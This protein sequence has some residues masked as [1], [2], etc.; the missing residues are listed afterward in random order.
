[1]TKRKKYLVWFNQV[2]EDNPALLGE[3]GIKLGELTSLDLPVPKG[4]IIAS[5]AYIYFLKKNKLKEKIKNSLKTCNFNNPEEL[6][7]T[8]LTIQNL[9]TFSPVPKNLG[10]KITKAYERLGGVF[11]NTFVSVRSKITTFLNIKGEANLVEAVRNCW[12]SFFN[13]K[14]ILEQE[15]RQLDHF[16]TDSS[17]VVQKMIQAE[18]SGIIYTQ[19]PINR[20][21]TNLLVEAIFGLGELAVEGKVKPDRY[22]V[23]KNSLE[24]VKKE[25][26]KQEIQLKRVQNS[27]QEINV[28][29]SEQTKQKISDTKIIELVKL[30]KKIHQHYFFPQEIEWAMEKNKIYILQ[31]KR[32]VTLLRD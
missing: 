1:M 5:D 20:S 8:S 17:V 14:A 26:N 18:V 24:I 31:T 12:A 19:D 29:L 28:S 16:K 13:P 32:G 9:I 2:H 6:K 27:N 22:L 11:K 15:K 10:F 25:L 7:E 23:D 4:F 21:K 3:K 30:G